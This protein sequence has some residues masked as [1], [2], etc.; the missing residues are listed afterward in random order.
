MEVHDNATIAALFALSMGLI[1]VI[2]SLAAWITK[3]ANGKNGNGRAV[4]V[5]LDPEVSRLI[6]ETAEHARAT[7]EVVTLRDQNGVPLIYASKIASEKMDNVT[8]DLTDHMREET[9]IFHDIVR[10]QERIADDLD[11]ISRQMTN[12][13]GTVDD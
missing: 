3:R 4:V 1:E 13:T 7:A 2:K 12:K 8:K 11:R 10:M 6:R 9:D 5:Q